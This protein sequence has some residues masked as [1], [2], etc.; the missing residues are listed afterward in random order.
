M[1]GNKL[2]TNYFID[3]LDNYLRFNL[4]SIEEVSPIEP[5]QAGTQLVSYTTLYLLKNAE[6]MHELKLKSNLEIEVY[7]KLKKIAG[8]KGYTIR[9]EHDKYIINKNTI[10]IIE[11]KVIR[12][13]GQV[14]SLRNLDLKLFI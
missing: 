5:I 10:E 6:N 9:K 1:G 14:T 13:N 7:K 11:G 12:V 8:L 2:I 4:S 3:I